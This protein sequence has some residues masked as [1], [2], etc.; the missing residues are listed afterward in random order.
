MTDI[1]NELSPYG[2]SQEIEALPQSGSNRKYFRLTSS[3]G[4]PSL[5]GVIGT[6]PEENRAFV[7]LSRHFRSKG[8]PVPGIVAV[9]EDYSAYIQEDLGKDEL[10]ACLA[11]AR[12]AGEY[13]E[14]EFAVL[15]QTMRRLAALQTKGG[16]GLDYS[17]CYP[18][19]SFNER[20]VRFDLNYFKY[21]FLKPS[22]IEFNEILLEDDIDRFCEAMMATSCPWGFMYRDFQSRNVMLKDGEPYFIDFQ[23]GR[24]G[25]VLYDLVSFVYQVRAAYPPQL[26]SH[27]VD[28]YLKEVA[29]YVDID[30]EAVRKEVSLFR[31]FRT[32]QILGAYGFRG[33]IEHKTIFLMS[34]P[35]AMEAL[36]EIISDA[37]AVNDYPYLK[38]V[39]EKVVAD[40]DSSAVQPY[41]S[42][43]LTV[44]SFSFKKGLPYDD[45][46]GGGYVF[47]C[48]SIHNPGRYQQYKSLTGM[49]KEV[50]DFL[51]DDGEIQGFLSH[52]YGVVEPHIETFLKRGFTNMMVSFGCTGGQHRSVY[53]AEHLAEHIKEMYPDV[54]VHLIHRERGIDRFL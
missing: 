46:N 44:Y 37:G 28:V 51:E 7:E 14:K 3:D 21:C 10:Y 1:L 32:L 20:M 12:A 6:D 49:D 11:G 47:D 41:D 24:K 22:G 34:I 2:Y 23:G 43:T 29:A 31:L 5:I 48:R 18:E 45:E 27:L 9:S 52:A 54:R 4:G 38:A 30:M 17:V 15:E 53:C 33:R 35:P 42:L 26:R 13:G 39:L 40:H 8:L 19:P 50:I 25:P 16:E 36:R